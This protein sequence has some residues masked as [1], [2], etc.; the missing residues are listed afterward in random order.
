[1]THHSKQSSI[2]AHCQIAVSVESFDDHFPHRGRLQLKLYWENDRQLISLTSLG[3]YWI[4]SKIFRIVYVVCLWYK[5]SYCSSRKCYCSMKGTFPGL[6]KANSKSQQRYVEFLT[7]NH[8]SWW[9]ALKANGWQLVQTGLY[10]KCH[11]P[12]RKGNLISQY[13]NIHNILFQ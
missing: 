9:E 13:F 11:T 5:L 8:Y 6:Q 1:M 7:G 2:S 12:R 10:E 3:I 4:Q